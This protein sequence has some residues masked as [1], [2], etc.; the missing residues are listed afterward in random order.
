MRR[1]L[2]S[3]E[4]GNQRGANTDEQ[5]PDERVPCE[6]FR[7]NE[8]RTNGVENE[9]GRLEGGEDDEWES[10]D[11]DR[12]AKDVG[13]YEQEDSD[14]V[15]LATGQCAGEAYWTYAAEGRYLPPSP[16]VRRAFVDVRA[17]IFE[18]MRLSLQRQS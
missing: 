2:H 15:S 14:L 5:C 7:E 1:L 9:T 8:G 17:I 13:D 11:L 6:G 4:R 10:G 3:A 16:A 12:G 18:Q